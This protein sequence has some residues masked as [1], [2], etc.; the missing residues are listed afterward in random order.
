[1][2]FSLFNCLQKE[3]YVPEVQKYQLNLF[4]KASL[5]YETPSYTNVLRMLFCSW[6]IRE[7]NVFQTFLWSSEAARNLFS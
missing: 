2:Y 3:E 5:L 6:P 7:R 4:D 1:M